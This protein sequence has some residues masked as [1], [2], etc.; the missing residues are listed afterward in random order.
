VTLADLATDALARYRERTKITDK[1]D[2]AGFN[3][4]LER[5]GLLRRRA[6]KL[7]PTG[8]AFLLFG[9]IPREV[10]HHAGLNA[11]IEYPDG[12]HEIQ[13][14]GQSTILIPGELEKWLRPKLPNVIDRNRMT[15]EARQDFPF[16]LLREAVINALVHRDYDLTGATCHLVVTADTVMVRSPGTPLAPVTLEQMQKFTA[17]MYNRN[18]K[19]Q[20]AFG[21]TKLV[22]GRGL[23][24]R[25]LGEAAS[26]HALPLPK[27]GF[28]GVYLNLTIYRNR[29]AAISSLSREVRE[30]LSKPELAGWEW[31]STQEQT[32]SSQYSAAVKIPNRTALRQLKRFAD[33]GLLRRTGSGPATVYYIIR[34]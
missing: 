21:G 30:G 12:T 18:P 19:L 24:M 32:T 5:Q 10:L 3:K 13:N 23:G 9:K 25:T 26:K 29:S 7:V 2:S 27:Y 1:L 34:T 33:L 11:T 16:E 20:F 22:E 28:D 15:H 14:F 17:P 4:R 8:F 6:S 31:L